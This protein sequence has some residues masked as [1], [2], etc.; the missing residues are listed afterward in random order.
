MVDPYSSFMF[1]VEINGINI[2]QFSEVNGLQIEIETEPYREGGQNGFEYHFP[3]GIKYQPLVLKR[4]ITDLDGL[5]N[6]YKEVRNG[7]IV[8]RM[9]TIRMYK[10]PKEMKT[11]NSKWSW[12]FQEAYPIKWTGP[13][14]KADSNTVAFESI[15]LVHEGILDSK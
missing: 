10:D 7:T 15:E 6:W 1:Y 3:K 14:L 11:K 9:V 5:W 8:R 13:V 4:G 2:A 12:T